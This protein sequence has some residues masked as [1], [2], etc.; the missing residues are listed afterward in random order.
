MTAA[1]RHVAPPSWWDGFIEE[2]RRTG[3]V[4]DSLE[5]LGL[6]RTAHNYY[7][8]NNAKLEQQLERA[9]EEGKERDKLTRVERVLAL[10]RT[11]TS[12]KE[13]IREAGET[14]TRFYVLL[15]QTGK[16]AE[17]EEIQRY[18]EARRTGYPEAVRWLDERLADDIEHYDGHP[19]VQEALNRVREIVALCDISYKDL[20]Q[21]PRTW[22]RDAVLRLIGGDY[23][24]EDGLPPFL[25]TTEV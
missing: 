18:W 12:V 5:S 8:S 20:E 17:F 22:L 7:T 4:G 16:T 14:R 13:A 11:G 3:R 6:K 2:V 15:D 19:V 1:T 9:V 10:L 25:E 23:A 24:E 21:R